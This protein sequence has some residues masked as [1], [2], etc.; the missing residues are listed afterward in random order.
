MSQ[1]KRLFDLFDAII[2]GERNDA[3]S[4]IVRCKL[5]ILSALVTEVM[6]LRRLL[7]SYKILP[8]ERLPCKTISVG[9]IVVGGSGK[10][11]TV[12]YLA[13][14][15]RNT[16]GLR[17]AILSRGYKGKARGIRVVSDG[18][19]ILVD[20][21]SAGDEPFLLANKLPGVP[22]IV[23]KDRISAGHIAIKQTGAEVIILDDGFQYLRLVKDVNVITIDATRPFGYNYVLPRGYLREPLS[24]LKEADLIL[25]TRTDQCSQLYNLHRIIETIAPSVP[26][27]DSVYVPDHTYD[28]HTGEL[29]DMETLKELNILAVCG[30]A[31]PSSFSETLSILSPKCLHL[32]A[33]PDHHSYD[34]A[35]RQHI[36]DKFKRTKSDV[37]ITTEKDAPKLGKL[38]LP[39]IVLAIKLKIV[40][41]EEELINILIQDMELS[42]LC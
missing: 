36:V 9:N 1:Y 5:N 13:E 20:V 16:F 10:T 25:L 3:L 35:T 4:S 38:D 33:F 27:F 31:N 22:V 18:T 42:G 7:Y 26:R 6:R 39:V 14:L 8:S 11:P 23:G 37:V 2:S 41:R 29:I 15:I 12:V 28:L 40:S 17:V 21:I 24:T 19:K 32:L 34:E 30:I